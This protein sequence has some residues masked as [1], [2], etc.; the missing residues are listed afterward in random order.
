MTPDEYNIPDVHSDSDVAHV[1]ILTNELLSCQRR[2]DEIRKSLDSCEKMI[3]YLSEI[4]IPEAMDDAG[5]SEI[6]L[7]TGDR[8]IVRDVVRASISSA[9]MLEAVRWLE[10]HD[11]GDLVRTVIST[12]IPRDDRESV[13][14]VERALSEIGASVD[15]KDSV[16]WATL[17]AWVKER[18]A[19]GESID[20]DLLGVYLGRKT[21]VK[22]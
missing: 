9:K 17:T 5:V 12:S 3:R 18:L 6:R 11:G 21:E 2:A 1:V 8:V 7:T 19:A 14:N 16:H 13:A 22:K 20:T 10:A 4:G 15:R